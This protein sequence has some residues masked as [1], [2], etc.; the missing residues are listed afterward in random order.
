MRFK[1]SGNGRVDSNV[2]E[3]FSRKG[4]VEEDR[5]QGMHFRSFLK[6]LY[7]N[8]MIKLIPQCKPVPGSNG[9]VEWRFT[10][11]GAAKPKKCQTL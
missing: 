2:Y 7:D 11:A 9:S 10:K 1:N 8:E 6:K 5:S 3:M 4:L